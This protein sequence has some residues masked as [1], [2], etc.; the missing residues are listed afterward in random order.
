MTGYERERF[1][2][3]WSDTDRN[4][5]D[6]RNDILRRDLTNI[7]I[8]PGTHGCAVASGILHDPY[9]SKDISFVRG[10]TTSSKV[11]IDHVLSVTVTG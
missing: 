8:K 7:V 4:G 5:C 10:Q 3:A 11:Q 2:Q 9:T 6:Q 1:G